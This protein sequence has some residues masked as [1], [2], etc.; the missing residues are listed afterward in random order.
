TK[1]SNTDFKSLLPAQPSP[2]DQAR[3]NGGQTF[4]RTVVELAQ[5]ADV[6]DVRW[7]NFKS[8]C[9]Q[10]PIVGAFDREW[11]AFFDQRAMPGAVSPGCTGSFADLQRGAQDIRHAAA[12][13]DETAR[14]ADVFP[15]TRRDILRRYRLDALIK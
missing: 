10:R 4:E 15:G 3:I 11:Y 14:Q 1:E 6:L 12:A 9:Y 13:A 5:R 7:R 8:A 2:T